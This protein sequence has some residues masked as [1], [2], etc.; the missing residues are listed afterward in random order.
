[1][2]TDFGGWGRGG[3]VLGL[4]RAAGERSLGRKGNLCNAFNNKEFKIIRKNL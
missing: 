4:G 2:D 3:H 1:M